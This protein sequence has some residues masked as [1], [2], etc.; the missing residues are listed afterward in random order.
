VLPPFVATRNFPVGAISEIIAGCPNVPLGIISVIKV[1]PSD[2]IR[3]IVVLF[4]FTLS[5]FATQRCT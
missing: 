1:S 2:K 5:P 4:V 3:R